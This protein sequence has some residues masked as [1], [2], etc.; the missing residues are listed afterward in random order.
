MI[1]FIN[2]HVIYKLKNEWW[3]S[4]TSEI[5]YGLFSSDSGPVYSSYNFFPKRDP[6]GNTEALTRARTLAIA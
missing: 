2:P 4:L 3:K 5:A 1:Y 6:N